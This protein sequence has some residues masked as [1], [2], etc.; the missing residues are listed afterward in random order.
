[1][2]Y[3][4]VIISILTLCVN[5]SIGQNILIKGKFIDYKTNEILPGVSLSSYTQEGKKQDAFSGYE[6]TSELKINADAEYLIIRYM[7]SYVIKIINIPSGIKQIDFG[8]IKIVKDFDTKLLRM[9]GCHIEASPKHIDNHN[10]YKKEIIEKY[11]LNVIQ[12]ELKPYFK[13]KDLIFDFNKGTCI[14][15]NGEK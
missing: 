4:I 12:K 6:G 15:S 1:M 14:K 10:R 13:G 11:R 5:P 8:E 9:D 3:L 2:K 7:S